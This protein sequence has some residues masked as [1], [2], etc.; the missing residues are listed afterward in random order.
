MSALNRI[1]VLLGA[2]LLSNCGTW[3]PWQQTSNT[4]QREIDARVARI[5]YRNWIVITEASFPTHS[6]PGI[7]QITVPVEIPDA[8]DY[9]LRSLEKTEHLRPKIYLARELRAV[10]NDFAPGIDHLRQRIGES[11]HGHD[12]TELDHNSLL[13]L[14]NDARRS[15]EI[16]LIRTPTALPYSSVFMEL[17]PGY[18]DPDSESRLR[19]RLEAQSGEPTTDRLQKLAR[20]F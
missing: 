5:G 2:S 13:T 6:R 7:T 4:W 17:Q 8:T 1:L 18:W 19:D 3:H 14:L 12:P 11:L 9:V 16:T 10:E 15:F 20:P